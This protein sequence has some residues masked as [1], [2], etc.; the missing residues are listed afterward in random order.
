MKKINDYVRIAH[1][2]IKPVIAEVIDHNVML[3]YNANEFN[4]KQW[5]WSHKYQIVDRATK[6]MVCCANTRKEVFEKFESVKSEYYKL[7]DTKQYDRLVK[8]VNQM[9][10]FGKITQEL[11]TPEVE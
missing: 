2:G 9:I 8:H 1:N 10:E 4:K 5:N 6:I 3:V 7:L 11:Q